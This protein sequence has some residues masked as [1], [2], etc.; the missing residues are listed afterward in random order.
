MIYNYCGIHYM[1]NLS[2]LESKVGRRLTELGMSCWMYMEYLK[3]NPAEWDILVELV[4]INE[5]YFFREDGQ[6]SELREL[7]RTDYRNAGGLKVWSA[8]CSTGEEPYSIGM[9]VQ[10]CGVPVRIVASDINKKVL[11]TARAG[12]YHKHSLCFRR[13]T[14]EQLHRF[15]DERLEGYEVKKHIRDLVDFRRVN[16]LDSQQ[17]ESVGEVD[18][19]YCRN[20]LIY[21]DHTT[22]CGILD[23][24]Y[25]ILKPGGYL[26]LG[27][28]ESI[29][30]SHPGFETINRRS[31]FYYRKGGGSSA[32]L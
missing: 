7:L 6:L 16:L 18:I 24:F 22:I 8:A 14:A 21:F 23:R 25:E 32:A 5:T 19:I 31:T 1:D 2:S 17:V 26:F 12:W 9:M 4:T 10:E 29:R 3:R 13:T 20:V 11:K 27:H 15:F 28:A 30:G